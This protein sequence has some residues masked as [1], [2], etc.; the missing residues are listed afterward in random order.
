MYNFTLAFGKYK[1]QMFF[2]APYSYQTWLMDQKFLVNDQILES[3]KAGDIV[4]LNYRTIK[5]VISGRSGVSNST[6][7][8]KNVYVYREIKGQFVKLNKNN[9]SIILT[10]EQTGQKY[11]SSWNKNCIASIEKI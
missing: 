4:Q 1:G 8:F 10:D 9:V 3:F 7:N 5:S 11:T 2:S 6:V